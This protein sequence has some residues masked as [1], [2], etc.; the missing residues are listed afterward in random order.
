[1]DLDTQFLSKE[2]YGNNTKIR[3][4]ILGQLTLAIARTKS[5]DIPYKGK[6]FDIPSSNGTINHFIDPEAIERF[7]ESFE[8]H[9]DSEGR[10]V[11]TPNG[12]VRQKILTD[13]SFNFIENNMDYRE[14]FPDKAAKII[15]ES[16]G[17]HYKVI[18]IKAYRNYHISDSDVEHSKIGGLPQLWHMDS[19]SPS[20]LR[21]FVPL[22]DV[23]EEN[24]PTQFISK[25]DTKEILRNYSPKKYALEP[26]KIEENAEI[27]DFTVDKGSAY[28]LNVCQ[29][30]H[31]AGI[32]E[33][34]EYRDVVVFN[35]IP[36]V[37]T[38]PKFELDHEN[39]LGYR[40]GSRQLRSVL[41]S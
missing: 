4:N 40:A 3:H 18:S 25:E 34:G 1:M 22:H 31:K 28:L 36:D 30:I 26:E 35:I 17:A 38:E 16:Y 19:F 32:P 11:K 29:H 12:Q 24:G 41:F 39:I 2:I 15:Q 27:K 37:S 7:K 23:K 8:E 10:H 13:D 9:I 5:Q 6:I 21:L 20:F 33:K 14:L